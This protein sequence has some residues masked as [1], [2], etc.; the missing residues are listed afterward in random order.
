MIARLFAFLGGVHLPPFKDI[1]TSTPIKTAKLPEQ[2]I[3]PLHQHIG[4]SAIPIIEVGQHV[5]K[6]Q[7]IAK[8]DG[9]VSAP[10]HAPTS[11][12]IEAIEDR[13]IPHPSGMAAPCIVLIPDGEDEW[14]ELA[15][16]GKDYRQMDPSE[17]RNLVRQAGIVGLGGAGF[18]TYIKH[19]PGPE[20]HIETLI[21]NGAECEPFITCDDMLMRERPLEILAGL[22][23]IKHAVGAKNCIIAIEDNK[24]QAIESLQNALATN[25]IENTEVVSVPT[26]YPAGS[27]KQLIQTLIGKQ[28]PKNG[29]PVH[30]GVV[31]QN[32]GTCAAVYRA[33]EYGEPLISRIVTVT[34]D[35]VRPCN[36]EVPI[37]MPMDELI[38]QCGS[39]TGSLRR[40]II[41]GPMMG[42]AMRQTNI[43][44]IK[45]TNCVLIDAAQNEKFQPRK[46]VMPCIRCGSCAEA[47]PVFLLPQQLY[48]Y[49]KSQELDK[50]QDYHVF[51]C[52]ECGCCDYVC[53]SQI[54]LVQYYRHA[55][56]EIWKRERE[57]EKSSRARDRH[58]FRLFRLEREK[59]EK[60]AKHK[61]KKAELNQPKTES[62]TPADENLND[63]KKAA[64]LAAM[65]RVKAKKS[66]Q[67]VQPKNTENLTTTQQ[68]QVEE[69][70]ERRAAQKDNKQ[71]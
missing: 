14:I 7:K 21:L 18:P 31:C 16:H 4:A 52:I 12:R 37:G 26:L 63:P 3:I 2:L 71:E 45:T 35:V 1:S 53:P 59:Q 50:L 56:A 30:I 36:L 32:V 20:G 67:N 19:N 58:E 17:L 60:A 51:D 23:I 9:Y 22:A 5:L 13:P 42:F 62:S 54:P 25:P 57:N 48:W 65:E 15:P 66:Q 43:P 61:Q 38:Q 27:E 34:G 6:G 44:I 47:C 33:I 11:G 39:T 28:I 49:S 46:P 70:N 24:P 29:L 64:I 68:K 55:K 10:V 40:L 41:G 69:A 8:A